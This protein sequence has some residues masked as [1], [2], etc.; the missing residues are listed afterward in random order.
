MQPKKILFAILLILAIDGGVS[1]FLGSRRMHEPAWWILASLFVQN[2]LIFA[3]YYTDS[4]L[5]GF[6]R[7]V[8]RNSSVTTLTF[9]G[10]PY[11]LIRRSPQGEKLKAI[12]RL[13][14]FCVLMIF[15]SL[16]GSLCGTLIG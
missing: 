14:G 7:S 2:A 5:R 8:W 1:G 15:S 10:I 12:F 9:I 3:W 6:K 16:V 11:Y 4:T 13:L